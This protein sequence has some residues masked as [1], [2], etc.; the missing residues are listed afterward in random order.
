MPRKA[1]KRKDAELAVMG[2]HQP[3]M[4]VNGGRTIRTL[5]AGFIAKWQDHFD[6]KGHAIFDLMYDSYPKEYFEGLIV[7][8]RVIRLEADVKH[9]ISKPQTITEALDELESK[10]GRTGRLKFEKFLRSMGEL[11][12]DEDDI[13]DAEPAE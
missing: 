11:E 13:I 4:I 1:T 8:S 6:K 5:S 7:M 10:V 3:P 9:T 12:D 2:H